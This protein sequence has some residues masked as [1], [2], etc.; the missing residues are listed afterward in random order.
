MSTLQATV[1]NYLEENGWTYEPLDDG[2]MLSAQYDGDNGT[3]TCF[4]VANE[5]QHQVVFYSVVPVHAEESALLRAAEFITRVNYDLIIGNFELDM[6][7][8]EI[9]FK[10]SLDVEGDELST[11]LVRNLLLANVAATDHY[12]P[13]FE[14]LLAGDETPAEILA[15]IEMGL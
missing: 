12:L 3:W 4:V 1:A 13:G 10:T 5:D 11:A 2:P 6:S 15:D 9:R 7:D 8:G 14:Q